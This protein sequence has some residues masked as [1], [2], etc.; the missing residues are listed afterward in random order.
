M[1]PDAPF[2]ISEYLPQRAREATDRA[3]VICTH[4][5]DERG[6]TQL[7]F[8]E[9]NLESDQLAWGLTELGLAPGTR[10]LIMLRP[11][12]E[13]ITL[14]FALF[15]LGAVP[16]LI[17]PGMGRKNLL[18]CIKQ[19][20]AEAMIAVPLAHA[21]RTIL[22]HEAFD[23]LKLKITAGRRWFWGGPTLK[24]ARAAGK[25]ARPFPIA[26]TTRSSPA[27]ILFTTG[28]TGIPKGVLY[29]H[30]MF[31]AQVEAIRTQYG[32]EPGEVDLPAFPLFALFST[33]L[34]TT[35]VIPEMDP[36]R[37]AQ[38]DP[39]KIVRAI[40]AHNVTYSFGS[41][42]I[43]KRV[44][45]YCIDKGITLPDLKR[46]LMAGAPVR[47]D[48]LAPFVKILGPGADTHIPY[49]ATE[50]LPVASIRG[51]EVLNET[52]A[53]T[54]Q[55]R[56]YCVG[57]P[58]AGITVRIDTPAPLSPPGRGVGGEG[59][60]HLISK[61]LGNSRANPSPPAPLPKR[62]RGELQQIGEILV[63]GAV[64]TQEYFEM[65]EQTRAAKVIDADG[66][67]WHRMGDM[68]YLDDTG[69]LWFCGRKAHRVV[70]PEKTFYSVCCEALFEEAFE[71]KVS[72]KCRAALVSVNGH[73]VIIME[74]IPI[75]LDLKS[76]RPAN[77]ITDS[78]DAV[79]YHPQPFPV[80]IRH[81]AKINR[82]QLGQWAESRALEAGRA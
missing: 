69:R 32:I 39:A 10:T 26:K 80:D 17:D 30:G 5:P 3:A 60:A 25:T 24:H 72:A 73:P 57:K 81:N 78:I 1:M 65:P 54:R 75:S 15:K 8:G 45:P 48:V 53:L 63:S 67:L 66:L 34:G 37:P 22:G 61:S 68:G 76:W 13:F 50:A 64:V 29:Q 11:G 21:I 43:W 70:T 62:E 74:A 7:S 40:Q 27:A 59:Q 28:S 2:N 71:K 6:R 12:L 49:G 51:S 77:P 9:M 47:G 31:G 19:V 44:G 14:T 35:C 55:G 56:G 4:S 58:L 33:A 38:C 16:V 46:I 41:P 79:L 36:T 23:G 82:E 20:R 42:A 18:D 52:W